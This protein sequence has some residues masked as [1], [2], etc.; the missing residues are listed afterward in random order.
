[1]RGGDHLLKRASR[2]FVRNVL[3]MLGGFGLLG[4][5]LVFATQL[6]L[7]G[8]GS[9]RWH[10]RVRFGGDSHSGGALERR[11]RRDFPHWPQLPWRTTRGRQS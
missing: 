6:P 10:L 11:A 9:L 2:E 4:A 1:M 3:W 7:L 8:G 5:I